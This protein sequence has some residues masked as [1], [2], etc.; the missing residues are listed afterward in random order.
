MQDCFLSVTYFPIIFKEKVKGKPLVSYGM[1]I[2]NILYKEMITYYEEGNHMP[3][4]Q[5]SGSRR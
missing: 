4:I 2:I 3:D 5:H 1:I